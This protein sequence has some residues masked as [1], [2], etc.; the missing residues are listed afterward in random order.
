MQPF[1]R[2]TQHYPCNCLN[3]SEARSANYPLSENDMEESDIES[4]VGQWEYNR[5][6]EILYSMQL[7]YIRLTSALQLHPLYRKRTL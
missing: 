2:A 3:A 1:G 4:C 7:A 5:R 6:L